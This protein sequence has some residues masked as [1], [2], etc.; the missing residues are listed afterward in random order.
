MFHLLRG[1]L[2]I[3]VLFVFSSGVL[4]AAEP[5]TLQVFGRS[6]CKELQVDLA[7]EDWSWLRQKRSLILGS[8]LPDFPPYVMTAS[9]TR[10]EGIAADIA[11]IIGQA[12]HVE[13]TV[14]AY[15]DRRDAM[16]AL[17]RGDI[18]MLG[19]SNS[20][21]LIDGL[22][23]LSKPYVEDVPAMF[24][25]GDDRRPMPANLA[26]L[27][28]AVADDYLPSS[29]LH[30]L[31]PNAEFVLFPS[32]ELALAALAFGKVDL[33]LGDTVSSNYL[34]NLTTSTMCGCTL[35]SKPKPAVSA[36]PCAGA[37]TNCCV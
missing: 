4:L 17:E 3:S 31:Y 37:T 36:L 13:I 29:Q 20:F 6:D 10:Y 21:E 27:R 25:R 8:A 32:N 30:A 26:G 7:N 33:F 16:A 1:V 28:I 12:L 35:S 5:R 11:C 14:K 22:V 18:D 34:I 15:P 24:M 2:L 19:S 23:T 9:G